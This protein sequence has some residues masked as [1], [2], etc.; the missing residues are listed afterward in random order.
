[1]SGFLWDQYF[2]IL[3]LDN[4]CK[5]KL[6]SVENGY[7]I[8]EDGHFFY[9]K[10]VEIDFEYDTDIEFETKLTLNDQVIK[11]YKRPG[12]KVHFVLEKVRVSSSVSFAVS[13][14]DFL[15]DI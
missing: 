1:M 7:H 4:K 5:R 12:A 14:F 9:E 10:A 11:T 8:L 2:I 3:T 13:C 6:V 15:L